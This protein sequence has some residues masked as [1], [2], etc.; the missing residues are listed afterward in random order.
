MSIEN[1][2]EDEVDSIIATSVTPV[3]LDFSAS[4]CG[5]CK[6]MLPVLEKLA[7]DY[8]GTLRVCKV[9]VDESPN[10][11]TRFGIRSVPTLVAF[12]RGQKLA[13]VSGAVP[14]ERILKLF[15]L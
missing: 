14:R 5:P 11:S 3:L 12:N 2:L 10:V 6:A 9:D 8:K 13:Q 15:D 4:W 7:E 1:V